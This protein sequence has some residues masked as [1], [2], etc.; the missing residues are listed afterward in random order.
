LPVGRVTVFGAAA[1]GFTGFFAEDFGADTGFLICGAGVGA[2]PVAFAGS[3]TATLLAGTDLA[4]TGDA[5]F[6]TDFTED[7]AAGL[8]AVLLAALPVAGVA[9]T[10]FFTAGL[11]CGLLVVSLPWTDLATVEIFFFG[12]GVAAVFFAVAGAAG[13]LLAATFFTGAFVTG[14]FFAA[15][16][17]AATLL[18]GA[19][20]CAVL[21]VAATFLAAAF[22]VATAF[23]A[24]AFFAT[25]FFTTAF[26]NGA[27]FAAALAGLATDLAA[28]F[29]ATGLAVFL[30]ALTAFFAVFLAATKRSSLD[31]PG[32]GKR[33][34]IAYPTGSSNHVTGRPRRPGHRAGRCTGHAP[35]RRGTEP[36]QR[37][38]AAGMVAT[39]E[40]RG[41]QRPILRQMHAAANH[42]LQPGT[43]ECAHRACHGFP[44]RLPAPAGFTPKHDARLT[45]AG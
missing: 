5:G 9:G 43:D 32:P 31:S 19:F 10:D 20:F 39:R 28:V 8:L 12:A 4:G 36:G 38:H 13:T 21:L 45:M 17:F 42:A 29:F 22:F 6:G 40:D 33:A 27:F 3:G 23:F 18:A 2:V 16:F 30:A 44:D 7:A 26:F 25:A 34:F 24:G 1:S 11:A 35:P 14:D 15:V 37:N 41:N